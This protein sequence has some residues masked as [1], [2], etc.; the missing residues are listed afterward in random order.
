MCIQDYR[1]VRNL[2]P[3]FYTGNLAA[4]ASVQVLNPAAGRM[5]VIFSA[6]DLGLQTADAALVLGPLVN[7]VVYPLAYLSAHIPSYVLSLFDVGAVLLQGLWINNPGAVA[8]DYRVID[9]TLE[10]DAEQVVN[11][12][13]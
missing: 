4:G 11:Q 3:Q 13:R 2:K 7:G 10:G 12:P 6:A 1:L 9:Q 5:V 8:L